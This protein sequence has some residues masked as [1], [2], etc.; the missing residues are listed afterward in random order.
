MSETAQ[1]LVRAALRVIGV[2]AQGETPEAADEQDGLQALKFMLR[3]WSDKNI[4]LYRMTQDTVALSSAT[5]YSIGSGGAVNTV[6]PSAIKGGYVKDSNG[7]DF[8]ITIIDEAKYRRISVKSLAGTA[9]YL[10]YNPVFP[11]G[12]LYFWPIGG[13]TAYIDSLKPLGE[14]ANITAN[15]EFPPGYDEAIK[16]NLALR[17]APEYGKEP[18]ALIFS[19]AMSALNDIETRNFSE[20]INAAE[21]EIIRYLRRFNIDEG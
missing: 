15:V 3:H 5:S 2:T 6:R 19:M 9:E 10:W 4:R 14:P 17:L 21:L 12:L 20:Q 18:S 16:W 13:G 8:P 1:T 11:L 7:F